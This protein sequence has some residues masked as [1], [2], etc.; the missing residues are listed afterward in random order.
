MKPPVAHFRGARFLR[1][2]QAQW[3]EQRRVWGLFLLVAIAVY[4]LL[5][6]I[7]LATDHGRSGRTSV[8]AVMLWSGL[9]VSGTVFASQYLSALRRPESALLLLTRPASVLEKWLLAVL[10]IAVA[11]PVAYLLAGTLINLAVSALG[12]MWEM[13]YYHT[14]LADGASPDLPDRLEY[15]LFI[16]FK[17]Y[18]N[19]DLLRPAAQLSWLLAHVGFSGLALLGSIYFR[20]I[21]G[22]KTGV[23]VFVIF[24]LT[25]LLGTTVGFRMEHLGWWVASP[26]TES[27]PALFWLINSLFWLLTPALLWLCALLALRER[28]LA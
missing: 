9:M 7:L 5:M 19:P 18:A 11:Y 8:Q 6:L 15:A 10:T 13:A 20:R 12:Y 17:T 4:A 25:L 22:I 16:P 14:R 24:L 26:S 28:D 21:A 3:A 2:L 27:L 23:V 1:L